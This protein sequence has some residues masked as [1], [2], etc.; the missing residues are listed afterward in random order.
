MEG[1]EE[2]PEALR[3]VVSALQSRQEE[4]CAALQRAE[5]LHAR[6]RGLI[7]SSLRLLGAHARATHARRLSS[8]GAE[9]LQSNPMPE[10]A[11]GACIVP[12]LHDA[13]ARA[14]SD[15]LSS[16]RPLAEGDSSEALFADEC[17]HDSVLACSRLHIM[18]EAGSAVVSAE[19]ADHSSGRLDLS[20]AQLLLSCAQAPLRVRPLPAL[21][22]QGAAARGPAAAVAARAAVPILEL[23]AAPQP[24]S[25]DVI[26]LVPWAAE[27]ALP[28]APAVIDLTG[29]PGVQPRLLRHSGRHMQGLG[30]LQLPAADMLRALASGAAAEPAS[31]RGGAR[32]LLS[33]QAGAGRSVAEA[34]QLLQASLGLALDWQ[35][36]VYD[37]IYHCFAQSTFRTVNRLNAWLDGP[38]EQGAALS[39]GPGSSVQV[40]FHGSRHAEITV[41]SMDADGC[42]ALS[43]CARSSL[44]AEGTLVAATLR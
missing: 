7:A 8:S 30:S 19:L 16:S 4:S 12:A 31:G 18:W 6:K 40:D 41:H 28:A 14:G 3:A 35:T 33:L 42:A 22:L 5:A 15:R 1:S 24:V 9:Q 23:L 17:S 44:I 36:G 32:Q 26:A 39:A 37:V 20:G 34:P 43:S 13:A 2:A 11:V 38:A 27:A 25:L 29:D 21:L 10:Q